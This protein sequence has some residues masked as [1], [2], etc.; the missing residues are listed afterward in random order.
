MILNKLW[1]PFCGIS[2]AVGA[3]L[4]VAALIALLIAAKGRASYVAAFS[5][6]G[7]TLIILYSA[8]ALYHS[9]HAGERLRGWL[10]RMDYV[11]IFLLIAGTYTPLCVLTLRGPRGWA[12]LAAEWTMALAGIL[13]IFFWRNAPHWPRVFLYISMGWLAVLAWPQLRAAL[14][15]AALYWLIAG[16]LAYTGGTVIYATDRPHL[17]PGKFSAHDLWHIF[18]MTG[19]VCH[20]VLVLAFIANA[21][22]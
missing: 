5:V 13:L 6:Y 11:S 7:A 10:Q 14:P 19:S 20:F 21:G 17:W 8:S 18:V 9:L 3:L 22:R 12:M 2:H 4:S 1:Q 15:T 16:G